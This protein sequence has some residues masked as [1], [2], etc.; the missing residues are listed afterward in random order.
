MK[1]VN[2]LK[3]F[4]EESGAAIVIAA[5]SMVAL[6][7]FTAIVIDGGS[8]YAEKSKQQKILDAAVL[9]GAQELTVSENQAVQTAKEIAMKNNIPIPDDARIET[10]PD[11][12]EIEKNVEKELS[13]AKILKKD[14]AAFSVLARAE[15][16]GN[17]VRRGGVVP[18]GIEYEEFEIGKSYTMHF[19]PGNSNNSSVS[20]N[21]GFLNLGKDYSEN[22]N[23]REA[24]INGAELEIS[25]E[26]DTYTWTKTG[27]SWGQVDQGFTARINAD[28]D[29]DYCDS[30]TTADASCQRVVF[31][32]II[33]TYEGANGTE[34]VKIVGFAS[35]WIEDPIKHH[36][37][38]GV[39]I[40]TVTIGEFAEIG[41]EDY[42]VYKVK[43]VK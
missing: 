40:D 26:G 33:E 28:S 17:L 41:E 2:V 21:F 11:Y 8:V 43:L 20:G 6:L 35:F 4:K 15:I 9:A 22:Q 31:T 34:E 36:E 18:V 37:V 32:P 30:P 25:G 38:T 23:L 14:S 39:F 5:L 10:G 19:Q 16:S 42:G 12:I 3:K 29:K 27:L 24:I 7:G 1:V 13:F